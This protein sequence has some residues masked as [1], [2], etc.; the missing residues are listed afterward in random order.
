MKIEKVYNNNVVSAF[1]E[2]NTELVIMGKGL[3][4]QKK[5]GDEIEE[6]KIEKVF[7]LKNNDISERFKTLLYEVSLELMEVAEEIIK[8]AKRKLGRELNDSIYISLTDHINF[9]IERNKKGL[10]IKNALLWEIKKLYK[11]EF[12]IGLEA[13]CMIKE[14]LEVTLPEDEAGFIAM[15]IVNAELNEE[16]PNIVNITKTMQDILKI[17]KYHFGLDFNEES[18][19]FFRF[20]THLKFFAQRLYSQTYMESDDDF[21]FEAVKNKHKDAFECTE[22]INDYVKRQFDYELTN[23]EKLYLTVHIERV[24]NR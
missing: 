22:K 18:L 19:N 3:A 8:L 24:V 6:E 11:D 7:T 17:V 20:V 4:F 10:D 16:M 9:A 14:K 1:N 15:H 12:S 13:L 23:D 2:E 5:P 21:L